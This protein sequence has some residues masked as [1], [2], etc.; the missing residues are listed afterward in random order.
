MAL[1]KSIIEQPYSVLDFVSMGSPSFGP[2]IP[3][4]D[5]DVVAAPQNLLLQ[6]STLV[7]GVAP[8]APWDINY[9]VPANFPSLATASIIDPFGDTSTVSRCDFADTTEGAGAYSYIYQRIVLAT[10]TYTFSFW[11]RSV[12]GTQTLFCHINDGTLHS[13]ANTL[14][15]AWQRYSFTI[16][17]SGGNSPFYFGNQAPAYSAACSA[18]IWGAQVSPTGVIPYV[19]TTTT[20][21]TGD[22][23]LARQN[24]LLQSQTIATGAA[25]TAPW[26]SDSAGGV[27]VPTVL[28]NQAVAPDGTMTAD[29]LTIPACT[30]AQSSY[31]YQLGSVFTNGIRTNS[32]WIRTVSGTGTITLEARE[33]GHG[34]LGDTKATVTETWQRISCTGTIARAD[35]GAYL[36]LGVDNSYTAPTYA[37]SATSY[38]IWGAQQS[39]TSLPIPYIATTTTATP[40]ITKH[41][42]PTTVGSPFFK[43]GATQTDRAV[44]LVA[45]G[46]YFDLDAFDDTG[47]A[48]T[49]L[50]AFKA[51]NLTGAHDLLT[52]SGAS[53]WWQF[54]TSGTVLT[55]VLYDGADAQTPT[56]VT[57]GVGEWNV[58]AYSFNGATLI[59]NANG[60]AATKNYAFSPADATAHLQIGHGAGDLDW[61]GA[62]ARMS[63]W[64]SAFSATQLAQI[65]ASQMGL[66]ALKP[67]TQ[68]ISHARSD[69][70]FVCPISDAEGYW[71]APNVPA[72]KSSGIEVYGVANNLL[73]ES[74][75]I[76]TGAAV[77]APWVLINGGGIAA[78]TV[79]ADQALSPSMMQT[80]DLVSFPAIN[81]AGKYSLI[82]QNMGVAAAGAYT[83]SFW[84]R[85]VTGAGTLY[86]ELDNGGN[87]Y[88]QAN[89]L[90]TTWARYSFT[91]TLANS[92]SYV[93][94]GPNGL[95]G[96]GQP[97]T[98]AALDVYLWGAQ[99]T[100]TSIPMPY[101][102]TGAA[103]Y[104]GAAGTA[105]TLSAPFVQ[106][107]ATTWTNKLLASE[108]I[109]SGTS[110][111]AP[112]GIGVIGGTS[113]GV[114][115][116]A[117]IAPDGS[118]SADRVAY[119]AVA[120]E[121]T[122]IIYQQ[123]GAAFSGNHTISFYA[124]T[125]TGIGTL[126]AALWTAG[127]SHFYP[128]TVTSSWQRFTVPVPALANAVWYLIIGFDGR[129]ALSDMPVPSAAITVDLWGV[130]VESGL[131]ASPYTP[132][133]TVATTGGLNGGVGKTVTNLCLQ[134]ET[135][136]TGAAVTAPWVTLGSGGGAPV[137]QA[138]NSAAS[139]DGA[140]TAD[141]FT[142]GLT[143]SANQTSFLYQPFTATAA[144]WS[145]SIWMR[146]VAGTGT[147]YISLTDGAT[148][149]TSVACAVTTTWTRFYVTRTAAAATWYFTIGPN[150]MAYYGQPNN[151]PEQAVLLWGAQVELGSYAGAY[152]GPTLAAAVTRTNFFRSPMPWAVGVTAKVAD[153]W[154]VHPTGY[155]CT[156]GLGVGS[157]FLN[158]AGG[159]E[160]FST[161]DLNGTQK[162]VQ[163]AASADSVAKAFIVVNDATGALSEYRNGTVVSGASVGT[164]TG[165]L[166]R[167][168]TTIGIGHDNGA[169]QLNGT[170]AK[171]IC[172]KTIK[173]Q[174]G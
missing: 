32:I 6:S 4:P 31:I 75:T 55:G 99:V 22:I 134:S 43:R 79:L 78:P 15:T 168:G 159:Q 25:L 96:S 142:F 129:A 16:S 53:K 136:A 108:T 137:T 27:A 40:T 161:Y 21:V 18:Y 66:L 84:A 85:T 122:A 88:S 165:A 70:T 71:V 124:K 125:V 61:N 9:D 41:G 104:A 89:S 60:T 131:V 141:L 64:K 58:V 145:G 123:L 13:Q 1:A 152:V 115:G 164:G 72:I 173:G 170:I 105:T 17:S 62:V 63:V 135:L 100:A 83:L 133:T 45:A 50:L 90:T 26:A 139:P 94:F 143:N 35:G 102:A 157:P 33:T 69:A 46:D 74:Q 91:Y 68:L 127:M 107:D 109:A 49:V 158:V 167:V 128:V 155:L 166:G 103:A 174:H 52:H 47:N 57:L 20:A 147:V 80:A 153:N 73:L 116:N 56:N 121:Q 44:G 24:Y 11:A 138:A 29:L 54:Y 12:S 65:V 77:T 110:I 36:I 169:T 163:A 2:G 5:I 156:V 23:A 10:G 150:T 162:Y 114:T 140:I 126:Y 160:Y 42:A 171:V 76:A 95:A 148:V 117:A 112:W 172:S 86:C 132:T 144:A 120:G 93:V 14:T 130:Q 97:D 151:Q 37:T 154:N 81:G 106:S 51:D 119:S 34:D 39:P 7:S 146:T 82:I 98:Q 28:A 48:W 87:M 92:G 101:R 113:V 67:N 3:E 149:A 38:Y 111:A 30:T 118:F 8:V 19:P 59:Q